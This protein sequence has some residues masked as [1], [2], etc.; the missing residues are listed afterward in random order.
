MT[1]PVSRLGGANVSVALHTTTV[2]ATGGGGARADR[3]VV[4]TY[5]L[6]GCPQTPTAKIVFGG[7]TTMVV[8]M[9][10]VARAAM[11][12]NG[13]IV[14]QWDVTGG[15]AD[16]VFKMADSTTPPSGAPSS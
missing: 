8:D 9:T 10:A 1:P 11:R 5:T 3:H 15:G 2:S 7:G 13:T 4:T 6:S 12:T 16:V 14:V